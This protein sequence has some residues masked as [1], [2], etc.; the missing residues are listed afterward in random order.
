MVSCVAQA[1]LE[2]LASNSPPALASQSAGITG[3]SLLTQPSSISIHQQQTSG[4]PNHERT[5][6]HNFYKEIKFLG[7]QLTKE[8]MALQGELQTTAQG[9]QSERT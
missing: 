2:L 1:G 3:V 4:E 6:I 8:V 7:T 5:S 9:N